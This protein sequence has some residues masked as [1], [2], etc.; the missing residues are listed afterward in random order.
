MPTTTEKRASKMMRPPVDCTVALPQY[1]D[2]QMTTIKHVLDTGQDVHV[3]HPDASVFDAGRQ[4][5]YILAC[6]SR[7]QR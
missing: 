5:C 4:G 7:D 6:S 1:G 2:V 3:I